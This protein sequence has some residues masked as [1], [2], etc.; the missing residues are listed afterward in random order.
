RGKR[1]FITKTSK[2]NDR[3]TGKPCFLVTNWLA[4]YMIDGKYVFLSS[5]INPPPMEQSPQANKFA[6]FRTDLTWVRL[7]V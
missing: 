7:L 5:I 6:P 2:T 4:S 1:H 3:M